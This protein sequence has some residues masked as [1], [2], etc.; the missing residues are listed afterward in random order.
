ERLEELRLS[1]LRHS[2]GAVLP[3]VDLLEVALGGETEQGFRDL[4]LARAD[5]Q[6]D[7]DR[8]EG[9]GGAGHPLEPVEQLL[10]ID[11]RPGVPAERAPAARVAPLEAHPRL[12]CPVV[13]LIPLIL[14]WNP[15]L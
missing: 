9:L 6:R 10:S 4:R 1:Q 15:A 3:R 14:L 5:R 7:V 12:S 11:L 8:G 2:D 13:W